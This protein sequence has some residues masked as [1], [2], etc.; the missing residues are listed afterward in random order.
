MNYAAIV[1]QVYSNVRCI[2]CEIYLE[3]E[4]MIVLEVGKCS[5]NR[6]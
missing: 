4:G 5:V 3:Q 2:I 6:G 1:L